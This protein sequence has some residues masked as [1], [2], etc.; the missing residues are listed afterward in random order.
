MSVLQALCQCVDKCQCCRP[1]VSVLIDVSAVGP[2]SV[3]VDRCQCC[4]PCVSVLIDVSAV[5]PVSVC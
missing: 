1:Y 3:R 4:R 2:V 5:G